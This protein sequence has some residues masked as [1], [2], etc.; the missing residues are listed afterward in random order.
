MLYLPVESLCQAKAFYLIQFCVKLLYP[1][2]KQQTFLHD[3]YL[4]H[5]GST[6]IFTALIVKELF[7]VR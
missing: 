6:C 3:K 1:I 7:F 2:Q 5:C 4:L